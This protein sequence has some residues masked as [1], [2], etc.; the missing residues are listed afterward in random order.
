[1]GQKKYGKALFGR[2]EKEK[3]FEIEELADLQL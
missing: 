1:M 3:R 2:K